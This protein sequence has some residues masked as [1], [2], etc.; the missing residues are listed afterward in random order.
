MVATPFKTKNDLPA[1]SRVDLVALLSQHL[2]DTTDLFTQ[3]KTAHWNVKGPNFIALHELFDKLAE[4]LEDQADT[5]A[6]RATALG[7]LAVGTVRQ[8]AKASRLKE[9]PSATVDGILLVGSLVDRYAQLATATRA[10]IAHATEL[11]DAGTAD[12]FTQLS[13]DLDKSLW[14]LE[15]HLQGG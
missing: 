3:V 15:A 12:L 5:I 7:G 13:R 14:F 9:P 6:E 4:E 2:A 1:K 11:D 8:A 10:A